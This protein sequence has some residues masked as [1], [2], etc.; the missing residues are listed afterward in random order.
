MRQTC[1]VALLCLLAALAGAS[2]AAASGFGL[3]QHGARATGQA[4]AFTARAS[5]PSAV[6]YNPAAITKLNG[7]QLEA[8]LDFDNP[9]DEYSSRTGSFDSAH[10]IQFPPAVYLTWKQKS[11]PFAL[12]LGVDSP[13]YYNLEWFPVL[14]PGR[15]L[16]RETQVWVYE[17]HPVLA[18][19]LGDGWSVGAGLR[20]GFGNLER[21]NNGIATLLVGPSPGPVTP[22]TVEVQRNANAHADALAWDA[23]VHYA[24]PSWGWGAVYRSS[25]KF[26]G[27]GDVKYKP[28]DVPT[29]IP[30]LNAALQANFSKGRVHESFEIPQEVR[31]GIWY[32]P[33]P[34]LRI[35]L[36]AAFQAWSDFGPTNTTYS[37][38][39]FNAGVQTETIPRDWK[40]TTSLRL[41]IEGN[42][43]DTFLLFGGV[44]R[45][46]SPLRS[47]TI[48]P[49]FVNGDATVVAAGFSIEIPRISFDLAYSYH[50]MD[51]EHAV[52]QEALSPG[53]AGTYSSRDQVWAAS[54][55]WRF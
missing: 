15:F 16:V 17:V 38:N 21:D 12:G 33:Y 24:A 30:G 32:A 8:G 18:Y 22:V 19:D 41:G 39:P 5:D 37:P 35:E 3:F 4:G 14:F 10:I 26:T 40:D 49:D 20:Y 48:V 52:N 54:V 1:R 42:I 44:A 27:D 13:F 53:V 51:K 28:L 2:L 45:E 9:T 11:G 46:Q 55:R 50:F 43:T 29:G 6:T 34:E 47:E 36:D 31:G 25:E 23:A 7:V